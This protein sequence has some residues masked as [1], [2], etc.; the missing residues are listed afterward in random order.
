MKKC[1]SFLIA[2]FF[3]VNLPVYAQSDK[4]TYEQALNKV[5]ENTSA[6]EN[7]EDSM[8]YLDEVKRDTSSNLTDLYISFG[9]P[10]EQAQTAFTQ[11]IQLSRTIMSYENQISNYDMN[12]KILRDA[13]ELALRT[14]LFNI[15]NYNMD[16]ELLKKQIN[17]DEK[18]LNVLKIKYEC[19]LLSNLEFSVAANNLN[20]QKNNLSS[21]NI[22][23]SNEKQALNKLMG[24][25][26]NS[27]IEVEFNIPSESFDKDIDSYVLSELNNSPV[28]LMKQKSLSE[29][30]YS[31]DSYTNLMNEVESE[32]INNLKKISREYED[33]RKILETNIRFA[34][35]NLKSLESNESALKENLKTIQNI[36]FANSIK[37]KAGVIAANE[38]EESKIN[39]EQAK[40]NLNKNAN[41]RA[42][43]IFSLNHS[44]L[45]MS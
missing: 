32:P 7:L 12:K 19:G 27:N 43:L 34:Y 10:I 14:H 21:L 9:A 29:A 31:V 4:I 44:Y 5:I 41:S 18:K 20:Q 6:I 45:L 1:F 39:I 17:L 38:L 3:V 35:N 11:I 33:T 25:D 15:N 26:I 36:Y 23:L 24:E 13:V 28:I 37:Y 8:I 42:S 22:K 40:A 16:I 2:F 30:Q